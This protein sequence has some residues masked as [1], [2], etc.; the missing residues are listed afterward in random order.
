MR[1]NNILNDESSHIKSVKEVEQFAEYLIHDL[2]VN[3][4]PD[5]DFSEYIY[6]L[7][8]ERKDIYPTRNK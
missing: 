7:C 4:N 6:M 5:E 2:G 8:N 1:P 3:L